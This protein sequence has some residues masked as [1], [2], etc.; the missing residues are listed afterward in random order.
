EGEDAAKGG[1][2]ISG[3]GQFVGLVNGAG[4]GNAA[5][6]RVLDDHAGGRIKL[7]YRFQ[8]GVG[9][10]DVVVGQFLAVQ[11]HRRGNGGFR[12]VCV[13][14]IEGGALVRVFPVAQF[15][16]LAELQVDG[17]GE[18]VAAAGNQPTEVI[19]NGTVIGGGVLIGLDGQIEALGEG[20]A[21]VV[22]LQAGDQLAIA[23]GLDD[24]GNVPVILGGSAH[25]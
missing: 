23:F 11:L 3:K 10:G 20:E 13:F 25:H 14:H 7:L 24:D 19:G 4:A 9:V 8:R 15:L 1:F 6:V 17:A 22:G 16:C 2:R 18:A 5:G 12:F 21:A